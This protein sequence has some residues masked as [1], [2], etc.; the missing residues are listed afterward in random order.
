MLIVIIADKKKNL[1]KRLIFHLMNIK[2]AYKEK[3][4]S[5]SSKIDLWVTSFDILYR[6]FDLLYT[7]AYSK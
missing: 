5:Y 1:L 3:Y 6:I 7:V 2:G 4:D